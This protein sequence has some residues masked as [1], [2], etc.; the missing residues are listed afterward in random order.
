MFV[1]LSV[2]QT[3]RMAQIIFASKKHIFVIRTILHNT[4]IYFY[5][6]ILEI[7]SFYLRKSFR[8]I[9]LIFNLFRIIQLILRC[10]TLAYKLTLPSFHHPPLPTLQ[11]VLWSFDLGSKK[12][13]ADVNHAAGM[14]DNKMRGSKE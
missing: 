4:N 9:F 6:L 14:T 7:I 8:D 5:S 3:S 11:H 2:F 1:R 12:T 13:A 10:I